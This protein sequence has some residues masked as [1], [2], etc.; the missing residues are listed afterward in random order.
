MGGYWCDGGGSRSRRSR[1]SDVDRDQ[2]GCGRCSSSESHGAGGKKRQGDEP[3]S[4]ENTAAVR[5][6]VMFIGG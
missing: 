4:D 1:G 5:S 2:R 3:H 6:S